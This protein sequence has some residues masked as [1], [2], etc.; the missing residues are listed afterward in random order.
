MEKTETEQQGRGSNGANVDLQAV[1]C[2]KGGFSANSAHSVF[3]SLWPLAWL[4]LFLG[5]PSSETCT[6]PVERQRE[7]G[8]ARHQLLV[9]QA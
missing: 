3:G 7:S 6:I 5:L 9:V 1:V 2:G 8:R 4:E